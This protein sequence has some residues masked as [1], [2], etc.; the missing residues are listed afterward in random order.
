MKPIIV[1]ECDNDELLLLTLG[2]PRK[3]VQHEGNRDEVVKY[4]LKHPAGHYMG[5][6]DEDPNTP[7]STKRE[8]FIKR[9]TVSDMHVEALGKRE[10]L[11]LR[12]FLEGW[13]CKAVHAAGGRLVKLDKGL[14]DDPKELHRLLS[15]RGDARMKKIVGFLETNSSKH[16]K[17]LRMHLGLAPPS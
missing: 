8:Q 6:V 16:L 12:P 3:R 7:R 13:L 2:V 10:L 9:S 17:E 5:M 4:I 14:S 11:V 1:V 15:P